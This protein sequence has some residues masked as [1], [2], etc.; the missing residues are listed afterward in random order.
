M[1]YSV[2]RD[3]QFKSGFKADNKVTVILDTA[4]D[5]AAVGVEYDPGSFAYTADLSMSWVLNNQKAWIPTESMGTASVF[6]VVDDEYGNVE[7]AAYSAYV[8]NDDGDGNVE[9]GEDNG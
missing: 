2:V 5:I 7:I 6:A 3:S 9:I 8:A 1:A 4:A